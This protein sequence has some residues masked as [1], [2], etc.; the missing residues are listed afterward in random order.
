MTEVLEAIA[1]LI[2]LPFFALLECRKGD[3][4]MCDFVK[5]MI[6]VL[7]LGLISAY[8]VIKKI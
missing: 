1:F 6:I 7:G 8:L 2:L 4:D 5:M 3:K